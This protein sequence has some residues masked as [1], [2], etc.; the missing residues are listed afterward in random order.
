MY[1]QDRRFSENIDKY[2]VGLT[3]FLASAIR[4]NAKRRAT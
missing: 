3:P 2:G 1:E 4:E